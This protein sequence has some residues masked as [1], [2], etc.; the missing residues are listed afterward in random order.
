MPHTATPTRPADCLIVIFGAS[1][2]LTKRKLA[3]AI[4]YLWDRGMTPE[5]FAVLGV[6]RTKYSDDEF[7]GMVR[8]FKPGAYPDDNKWDE[9]SK[10]LHYEPCDA[11]KAD[12]WPDLV[13][14]IKSI[15]EAHGTGTNILFY[16]SMA[17]QFFEPIID[18]IGA[19][20]LVLDGKRMVPIDR[21]N[22][23]WQRIVVEKPFGS[24][25]ESAVKLNNTLAEVFWESSIYRIDHYLGKELVQNMLV[26]RFA[27]TIFE[28]LWS[29][30]YIDH[31]QI[32]ASETVG[33]EGRGSYYDGPAGGA[34]RDMVQSHLLQ[35][36]SLV[37]MEPP[38]SM[39]AEDIRTEKIK[40]FKALRVPDDRDISKIA[41]RGQYGAGTVKGDSVPAYRDEEG[42]DPKSQRDT[43]AAM[44]F[45]VDTWRWGGVPFYLRSGKAMA[46]KK[47]EIVIY[48]RP[49][50]HY[51]F[52]EQTRKQKPNQIVIGIQPDEGIRLRF[53]GKEPG[54]GM[55][56]NEVV[57]DFDYVKQWQVDPPDGYATLLSDCMRG[58]QTL[59]K[60]RDE[61]EASWYACQPVLDYWEDNPQDD[62][63]NYSAGTW[64]PPASDL[65]MQRDGRY[66][67]ND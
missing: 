16:L 46:E 10:H 3:P 31:V 65:M 61:I 1:G 5:N 2:D 52:R 29:R 23:T 26:L 64:G 38:V 45:H 24:D 12:A 9:F 25:P 66:W 32:T 7:R 59:F 13:K 36:L 40:V 49:T 44:Q 53:E 20:G 15:S 14:R 8:D 62:L 63:P 35:V 33:V 22:D 56:M 18:N 43:F 41:V 34:M 27:N 48:F 11:T 60:H 39:D 21:D 57:M 51:L 55:K 37:A 42:V 30:Q 58:D 4:S 6:S 54:V 50:P 28:P 67:R 47:T 19:S 17:P